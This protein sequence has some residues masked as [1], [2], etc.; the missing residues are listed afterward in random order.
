MP[1]YLSF[2]CAIPGC[3]KV[4]KSAAG[5]TRHTNAFHCQRSP[6]SELQEPLTPVRRWTDSWSSCEFFFCHCSLLLNPRFPTACPCNENGDNLPPGTIPAPLQPL[7]ATPDNP[8]S[9]FADR[10]AF[11]FADFHFSDMQSS[12]W[13]VDHSLQLWAAQAAKNG[14]D[15]VPWRSARDMYGTIDEI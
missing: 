14:S 10:L 12:E 2:E 9:P 1:P 5:L 3:S 8:F 11:E 7:D 6:N 15:D 13:R 4:C